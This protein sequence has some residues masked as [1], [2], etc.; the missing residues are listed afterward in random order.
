M[1]ATGFISL[2]YKWEELSP[3]LLTKIIYHFNFTFR[4][5]RSLWIFLSILF[6]KISNQ[7]SQWVL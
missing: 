6:E 3:G 4:I 1:E 5:N 7:L 2:L